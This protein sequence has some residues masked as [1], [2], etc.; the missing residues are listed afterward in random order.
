M[1]IDIKD[2]HS[3]RSGI[4]A[5]AFIL[6]LISFSVIIIQ[7]GVQLTLANPFGAAGPKF[8]T[9]AGLSAMRPPLELQGSLMA[10]STDHEITE[11]IF[12]LVN[13]G[14]AKPIKLTDDALTLSYRDP[15][16]QVTHLAW[17]KRFQGNHNQDDL[18]DQ[19][20]L[21]QFTI[22]LS[23]ALSTQL[24]PNTAF[25]IDVTPI[26]GVRL[27]ISRTTPGDFASIMDFN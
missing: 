7:A 14:S 18:L 21:V 6:I 3:N 13:N 10:R 5:L 9:L 20:E 19:G 4:A 17:S 25:V 15:F 23:N 2:V 12:T 24:G 8:V 26:Q 27:S 11:L 16:Q 22:H 1:R